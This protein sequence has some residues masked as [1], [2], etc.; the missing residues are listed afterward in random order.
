MSV[1]NPCQV[2]SEMFNSMKAAAFYMQVKK[3]NEN[4]SAWVR[5]AISNG[6]KLQN[7]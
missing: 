5:I 6:R 4:N 1:S 2:K 7:N 3:H